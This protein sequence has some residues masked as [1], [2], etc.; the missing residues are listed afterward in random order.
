MIV[1]TGGT[2]KLGSR[3]VEELLRRVPAERVGVSVR[4]PGRAAGLAGR[5]VRVRR[6][7]FADPESLAHAFEGAS[8]VLVVST[9]ETG[10]A[11]LGHHVAAIDAARDA[12]AERVLYTSH[13][14]AA[15]D[16]LFAPMPD[17][18]ATERHLAAGPYTALR[19]GF[20]ASTVPLLVGQARETG[21]LVA[22]ADGPVSWTAHADLAEAA[23]VVLADEGR[24]D[25][26]TPPLTAPVAYDLSEVAEML[27]DL[28]GRTIRRVV[29]DDD[30]WVAGL[31]GH[32][33][34]EDRA[35]LLLGMFRAAR[36]G[37]F[38]VTGP[39]LEDLLG[40]PATPLRTL[41]G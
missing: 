21:E 15:E 23:A 41:I 26:A 8:Q 11:A 40:R 1:I 7:D 17:H 19:N 27:G 39:D 34:P 4:E 20:Y 6:G 10:E 12:G 32:G 33:V 28:T 14:A 16:S 13:Q 5:G 9:D 31:V 18:A 2:G 22:P 35:A 24:F 29:V 37:E 30:E 36:R 3:I 25:G 38:A